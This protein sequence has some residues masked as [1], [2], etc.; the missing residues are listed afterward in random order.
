MDN[1]ELQ[2]LT[3][4]I[5]L[6]HFNKP[7][8]HEAL[9]NNRLSATGGRYIL[10][11]HNIEISTKQYEAFGEAAITEIIKHELVHYHLHIEGKGYRH[12]DRDFK[13]LAKAV[14]AP[15]FCSPLPNRTYKYR[16]ICKRCDTVYPRQRRMS[17]YRYRCKCGGRLKEELTQQQ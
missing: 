9:F 7:F 2:R 4:N 17:T 13:A 15:R 16:Y 5:S 3:E 8:L 14:G 12:R 1:N 10:Q 6:Q 11:S